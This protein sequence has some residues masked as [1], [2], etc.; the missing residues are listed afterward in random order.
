MFKNQRIV[1]SFPRNSRVRQD[2]SSLGARIFTIQSEFSERWEKDLRRFKISYYPKYSLTDISDHIYIWDL[3]GFEFQYK[4]TD[5]NIGT[6]NPT[7]LGDDVELEVVDS[8]IAL[9]NGL[10][11]KVSLIDSILDHDGI[12]YD[13][14]ISEASETS[15]LDIRRSGRLWITISNVD[16]FSLP[17]DS[18]NERS[19]IFSALLRL[20]GKDI[21]GNSIIE[22]IYPDRNQTYL[23]TNIYSILDNIVLTNVS[24]TDGRI[25]IKSFDFNLPFQIARDE[26]VITIDER[27]LRELMIRNDSDFLYLEYPI[28]DVEANRRISSENEI[29]TGIGLFDTDDNR[30]FINDITFEP[31]Q[32]RLVVLSSTGKL[33]FY[34]RWLPPFFTTP[35]NSRTLEVVGHI[36]LETY[37]PVKDSELKCYVFTRSLSKRVNT[38]QIKLIDPDGDIFYLNDDMAIT[39][40]EFFFLGAPSVDWP[41]DSMNDIFF[42]IV[43]DKFGQWEFVITAIDTDGNEYID[44]LNFMVPSLKADKEFDL[45]DT[46]DSISYHEDGKIYCYKQDDNRIDIFDMKYDICLLLSANSSLYTRE[47]YDEIELSY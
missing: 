6:L 14:L 11:T 26:S 2:P 22:D 41:A 46:Y 12:I 17:I 21:Y 10:P 15:I 18:R 32:Q 5:L 40:R 31:S 16:N 7:I 1:N 3:S 28:F 45:G 24:D 33:L 20:E 43:P 38:I 47:T 30:I 9:L 42:T 25:T 4:D 37:H 13:S 36:E 44:V 35:K 8:S 29:V 19:P 39:D 23:T 27:N 34:E